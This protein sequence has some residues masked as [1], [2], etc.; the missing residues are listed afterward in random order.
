MVSKERVRPFIRSEDDDVADGRHSPDPSLAA[1]R[2][3]S[4]RRA[5]RRPLDR[6]GQLAG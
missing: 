1:A 5:Q 4:R 6:W 2:F 3:L